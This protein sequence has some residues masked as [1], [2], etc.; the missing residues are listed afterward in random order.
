MQILQ[1]KVVTAETVLA[2]VQLVP[3]AINVRVADVTADASVVSKKGTALRMEGCF[4]LFF[5]I[6]FL[7]TLQSSPIPV[8]HHRFH[9]FEFFS[10]TIGIRC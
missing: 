3:V 9:L 7:Q 1:P 10:I 6:S 4:T 2:T 5:Q 8:H